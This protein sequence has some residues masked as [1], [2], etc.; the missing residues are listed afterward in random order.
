MRVLCAAEKELFHSLSS[1]RYQATRQPRRCFGVGFHCRPAV[2]A[3]VAADAVARPCLRAAAPVPAV[4]APAPGAAV[5]DLVLAVGVPA[6]GA[7]GP[8]LVLAVGAPAPGADVPALVLAVDA[9]APGAA[10]P[11][12]VLAVD[13]PAPGAGV[14]APVRML[15][16]EPRWFGCIAPG[17]SGHQTR[18]R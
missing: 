14:P 3:V 5:H 6:L 16:F 13:A 12:L 10:A 17:L 11:S 15:L 4:G 8:D 1:I 2:P 7:A 18:E 9:P